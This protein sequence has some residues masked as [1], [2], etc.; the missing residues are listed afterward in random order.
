MESSGGKRW[1]IIDEHCAQLLIVARCSVAQSKCHNGAEGK[2]ATPHLAGRSR[3]P[4]TGGKRSGLANRFCF[5]W[6]ACWLVG[7]PP[8]G[9]LRFGGPSK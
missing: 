2:Q 5:K 9:S 6:T 3:N 7:A 8:G 1:G 4:A